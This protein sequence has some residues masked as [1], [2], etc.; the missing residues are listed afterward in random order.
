MKSQRVRL[1]TPY[2][3]LEAG[4][5]VNAVKN[6][7]LA[8]Q[9]FLG[10]YEYRRKRLMSMANISESSPRGS[11]KSRSTKSRKGTSRRG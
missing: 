11:K 7:E 1:N 8:W 9:N 6:L 5:L 10:E 2:I 4:E 3:F